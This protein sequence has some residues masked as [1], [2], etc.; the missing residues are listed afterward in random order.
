MHLHIAER[1]KHQQAAA[2]HPATVMMNLIDGNDVAIDVTNVGAIAVIVV[3]VGG[4]TV[5]VGVEEGD[6]GIMTGQTGGGETHDLVEMNDHAEMNDHVEMNVE[7]IDHIEMS[8][9]VGGKRIARKVRRYS[10]LL[11]RGI[12]KQMRQRGGM[13]LYKQ[14]RRVGLLCCRV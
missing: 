7:R 12:R 6:E 1:H 9:H 8:G 13:N 2:D 4:M 5:G 14:H 3:V 10:L 11:R